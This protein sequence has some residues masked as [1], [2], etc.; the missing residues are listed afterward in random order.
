MTAG[1]SPGSRA[2]PQAREHRTSPRA[3]QVAVVVTFFVH[4]LLFASWTAH[5][6]H[7]K[8]SLGIN[9]GTLG[10]ALL[11]TPLGSVA[12]MAIVGWA[13]PR[14][15]SRAAVRVA[16]LGYAL[17][18]PLVGVTG[19]VPGL[20]LALAL[21]GAFQGTLDVSMN[22]QA[23]AVERRRRRP[24]MNGM[25]AWWS[26]GAFAGAG[27]GA[28]GVAIGLSLSRQL[29]LLAVPVLLAGELLATRMLPDRATPSAAERQ[30]QP[31][32]RRLSGP[33]LALGAI[34]F[35]AMLC[36]GAAADWSSVYLRESAGGSPGVAGLGYA[37]FALAMVLVRGLGDRL[38]SRFGARSVL[39]VLA[40]IATAAV[41]LALAVGTVAAMLVALFLL[42]LGIGTVVP[43]AFSAAGRLPGIHPGRGV[44]GVSALGWA[45]FVCGPPIIGQ[46]ADL[47]SLPAALGV[48]PLLTALVALAAARMAALAE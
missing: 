11:G 30:D 42:G 9:D 24:L 46:L 22:T 18:G 41:A 26:I 13:L 33:V 10:L 12:A 23:I 19:S 8:A 47:V 3:A 14:T 28:L 43:T 45:G 48:V 37:S 38:L 16:L 17:A 39:S 35:A 15:G 29:L 34:A 36:E 20:F 21:W 32:T 27:V 40:L 4:G 44:A 7:V 31:R 2:E 25:H 5:I 6:P 1:A